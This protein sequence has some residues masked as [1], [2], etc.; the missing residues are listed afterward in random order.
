MII[1]YFPHFYP[2]CAHLYPTS[3]SQT[4][5]SLSSRSTKYPAV[6]H[7]FMLRAHTLEPHNLGPNPHSSTC[8]PRDPEQ[9]P[10]WP[11]FSHRVSIKNKWT[12]QCLEHSKCY[13]SVYWINKINKNFIYLLPHVPLHLHLLKGWP[14]RIPQVEG[15]AG[16]VNK[17]KRSAQSLLSFSN[18]TPPITT[19]ISVWKG[20]L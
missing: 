16:I 5:N 14:K 17:D 10:L 11:E 8:S 7:S 15:R 19:V 13:I 20:Q 1:S 4:W 12:D 2:N 18:N 6:I 9:E 3:L